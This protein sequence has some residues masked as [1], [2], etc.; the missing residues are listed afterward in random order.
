M[1]RLT[2]LIEQGAEI[3]PLAAAASDSEFVRRIYLDLAGRV[4][5][6]HELRTFLNDESADKRT[7]L[8]DALLAGPDYPR[9]MQELFNAMLMERRVDD[10]AWQAFL[11]DSFAKNRPWDEIARSILKP[12]ADDENTRSAALFYTARLVSEGAMAPVDVPG[13]TRDVGRMF[14]GVDLQ[15]AQC[16]D[17]LYIDDYKQRSFQGLHLIFEN[18]TTRRDVDFPAV[19]EKILPGKQEYMSVFIQKPETVGVMVPGDKEFEIPTFEKGE[20]YLVP[21]DRKARIP[22]VPK[23]SP[24]KVL[25]ENLAQPDNV[26]F[27]RNIANRLWFVMMGRGLVEPLDLLH[28]S[29]PASHPELLE[30]LAAE[31]AAHKF[32]IRWFLGQLARTKTYQRTSQIAADAAEPPIDRFTLALEKRLSAEQM[33]WSMLAG[34]GELTDDGQVKPATKDKPSVVTTYRKLFLDAF[35]NPPK[36]PEIEYEPTVKAA[37]FLS[38]DERMLGFTRRSP[39]N[40]TDRLCGLEG[41]AMLDEMFL[42]LLAREPTSADKTDM[43]AYLK[44][45]NDRD[46]AVADLVWSL[47]TSMEFCINH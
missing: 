19:A 30:L 39:G 26:A 1:S 15:C 25:A 37:L 34:M 45:S 33:L 13:L 2:R 18:L 22:G 42:A 10:E 3:S 5:T 32:D 31:F 47:L 41:D 17:H 40:L 14:A 36:E 24:L 43:Q 12:D 44:A 46:T 6:L 27:R 7:A 9:R 23:F 35:A 11:Q 16:H 20:E 38:N 21:P 28:A 8:I 29:N 4:P